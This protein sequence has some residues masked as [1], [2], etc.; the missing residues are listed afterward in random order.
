MTLGACL[1]LTPLE[2]PCVYWVLEPLV[3]RLG[4]AAGIASGVLTLL[5][6]CYSLTNA[7]GP[8]I[9]MCSSTCRWKSL[10]YDVRCMFGVDMMSASV[11]FWVP[12]RPVLRPGS[13]PRLGCWCDFVGAI[14]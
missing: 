6:W 3:S 8:L 14:R 11:G 13:A 1:G 2:R 5:G 4:E 12:M 10:G 9:L 7:V